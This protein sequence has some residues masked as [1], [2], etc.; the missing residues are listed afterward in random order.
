MEEYLYKGMIHHDYSPFALLF[1]LAKKNYGSFKMCVDSCALNKI[2][3]KHMYPIFRVYDLF[4][5]LGG[6][7]IFSKIYLKSTTIR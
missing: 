2:T 5:T 6:A 3:I 4:D 1:L 7:T